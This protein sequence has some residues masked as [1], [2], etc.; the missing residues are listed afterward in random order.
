ML[1]RHRNKENTV[2]QQ[3]RDTKKDNSRGQDETGIKTRKERNVKRLE[4]LESSS[5]S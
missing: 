5:D 2:K 4:I 3:G 1:A